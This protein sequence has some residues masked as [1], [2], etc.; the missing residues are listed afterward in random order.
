MEVSRCSDGQI[1]GSGATMPKPVSFAMP[2]QPDQTSAAAGTARTS[3]GQDRTADREPATAPDRPST[4]PD[5]SGSAVRAVEAQ[6]GPGPEPASAS[7]TSA[8]TAATPVTTLP[9]R[10]EGVVRR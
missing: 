10:R 6:R 9:K 3:S 5:R 1:P 2:T 8:V 7:G 4:A